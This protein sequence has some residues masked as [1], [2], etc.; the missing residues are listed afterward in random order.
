MKRRNTKNKE[1]ILDIFKNKHILTKQEICKLLPDIEM[2]TVY[3]NIE[4]FV[5]DGVLREVYTYPN[6]VAYEY[7]ENL[8]DHF[9]CDVCY[10]VD[11]IHLLDNLIK[12]VLPNGFITK[13]GGVVIHGICK[14]CVK[15]N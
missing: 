9:V 10:E 11:K 2:S 6:V 7:V 5:T 8:H 1:R 14:K 4:R 13:K 3:R 15:N 12:E